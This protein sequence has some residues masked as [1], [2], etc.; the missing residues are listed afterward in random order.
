MIRITKIA[1]A[2]F[3]GVI[4]TFFFLDN[5]ANLDAA[6][7]VVSYVVSGADQP[8]Y[9]IFGPS[10]SSEWLAYLALF[11]IMTVELVVGALG[12]FGTFQMIKKRKGS[13]EDFSAAKASA[14]LA[15]LIGMLFWYGFFVIIGEAYF[16][17]WQTEIGLGS[18]EGAFRYGTVC[19]V[20][21]TYIATKND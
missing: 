14:I 9:K 8:H 19:A 16:Q 20:L 18:A 13:V 11:L 1:A 5:L 7:T 12:F 3:I 15:G 6:F 17:M 2:L 4:G 10:I 21:M